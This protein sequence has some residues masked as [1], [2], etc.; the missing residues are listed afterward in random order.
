MKTRSKLRER[1][2]T[3]FFMGLVTFVFISAVSGVHV[4]TLERVK[5]NARLHVSR[6]ILIAAG[7]DRTLDNAKMA[8]LYDSLVTPMPREGAVRYYAVRDAETGQPQT[9]VFMCSGPG[10]WGNILTAV[11]LDHD[12]TE[13]AGVCFVEH[14]ETPGLGARISEPWF[15][16][17]FRGKR[18]PL[19]LVPEGT[20]SKG[21][22]EIDALT[23]ATVTS[24]A[25]RD[26]V[27]RLCE[28]AVAIVGEDS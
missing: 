7:F 21:L 8:A 22:G 26:I 3:V 27:N 14:N 23:G 6:A 24:K 12:L 20:G 4:V 9:C 15:E 2:F 5:D 10:L 16:E 19:A 18:S 25:V 1:V 13:V 11:A 17:Q 28:E